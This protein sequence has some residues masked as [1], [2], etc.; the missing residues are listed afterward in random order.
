VRFPDASHLARALEM[1]GDAKMGEIAS[2]VRH[3][4]PHR[5]YWSFASI[6]TTFILLATLL[7]L[8]FSIYLAVQLHFI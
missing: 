6:I 4:M 5:T 1:F 7:L 3:L 8:G 2:P